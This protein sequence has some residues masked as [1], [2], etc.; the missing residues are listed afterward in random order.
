M[1]IVVNSQSLATELRL[2]AKVVPTKP[3][4]AILSHVLLTA[5]TDLRFWATDLEVGFSSGCQAT[6]VD[7]G[8]VALP[9]ARFLSLVEQFPNADVSIQTDGAK[10][11]VVCGAFKSKLMALPV[12]DFPMPPPVDGVSNTID[13]NAFRRLIARTEYAISKTSQKFMLQG[14]LFALAGDAAAM[15]ATDGKRLAL[16]TASRTGSDVSLVIPAKALD[17]LVGSDGDVD[18]IVGPKHMQFTYGGRTLTSRMIEGKFPAYER[19]IPRD[20]EL[21][22]IVQRHELAAALRRIVLVSEDNRATYL[23]V[24]AG[25]LTLAARSAEVGQADEAVKVEYSGEPLKVCVNGSYVLDFLEA[26]SGA[27]VTLQLK[28]AS[29]AMMMLDGD[30]H[31]G[32]VMLLKG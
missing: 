2:L 6:V 16:A 26:A 5:D 17:V 19:I 20:N 10:V 3:A 23:L 1:Q 27:T 11:L 8:N 9:A 18:V 30:D 24:E 12:D 7:P 14:A 4:I 28:D 32:V 21:T 29:S 13:G 15:V 31:V 25:K 22:V